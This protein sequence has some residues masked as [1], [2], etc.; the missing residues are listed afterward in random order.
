MSDSGR[1]TRRQALHSAAAAGAVSL[2][3]PAAA[4]AAGS[5]SSPRSLAS[6]WLGTVIGTSAPVT[7]PRRFSLVGVAW[8]SNHVHIE[9]R[10]RRRDGDWGP[11]AGA[12]ALGHGPDGSGDSRRGFGQPVW[13]GPADQV[14]LRTAAPVEGVRLH[15][16][17]PEAGPD[18]ARA[19]GGY[20]LAAPRLDAGPGQPAIIA[21]AAWTGGHAPPAVGP[22]YGAVKLAFVHHSETPNGYSAAEVPAMLMSIY[23]YHRFVQ[24]WH[25]IGYNF[26]VDA[27]GRIWEARA[28]GIEQAVIGAQAGGYNAVSTGAVMLGSFSGATPSAAALNALEHLLAWKLSLHGVPVQGRITVRVNPSDAYYTPFAPGQ[29]VSL[30]RVAGHRD[31]DSTNCPGDALYGLLPRVRARTAGLAQGPAR[32]SLSAPSEAVLA[33]ATVTLTGR[34]ATLS[35]T[36]LA[37]EPVEIQRLGLGGSVTLLETI[38]GADGSWS[39]GLALLHNVTLGALHRPRPAAAAASQFIAVAPQVTLSVGS[40]SPPQVSGSVSPAKK[41]VTVE[42][43]GPRGRLL[44]S[45]RL[46]VRQGQFAATL[47]PLAPGDYVL[48]AVTAADAVNAAGR[49]A[50]VP[51]TVS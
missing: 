44:R 21:R 7:A 43:R 37:S 29:R 25:D 14:Q 36:P 47:R 34:L 27:F 31:G 39:A 40:S 49:S 18:V 8:S 45:A 42:V 30:P 51:V 12:S 5:R 16:V 38:T 1:L 32:L 35:G 13:T 17:T 23:D 46:A 22:A 9:L 33:G 4:L 24:G 2:V 11:W 10:T 20:P 6:R 19:A 15:F 50:D 26:A 3:G 28:G 48:R 41:A